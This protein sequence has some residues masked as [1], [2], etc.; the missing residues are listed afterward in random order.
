MRGERKNGGSLE[1]GAGALKPLGVRVDAEQT[2][3][4]RWKGRYTANRDDHLQSDGFPAAL[5]AILRRS[6]TKPSDLYLLGCCF[7]NVVGGPASDFKV[8]RGDRSSL[9][10][11]PRSSDRFRAVRPH[12]ESKSES[13]LPR[14]D[15]GPSYGAA[16]PSYG[17]VWGRTNP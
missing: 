11:T 5:H 9:D 7:R 8:R 3:V 12:K 14:R 10:G 15:P 6:I 2:P 13:C 16:G 1:I 17:G 4:D